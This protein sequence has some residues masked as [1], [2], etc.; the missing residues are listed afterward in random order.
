MAKI[1]VSLQYAD[2]IKHWYL[3]M[4]DVLIRSNFACYLQYKLIEIT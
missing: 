3:A 4:F 2:S 1:T